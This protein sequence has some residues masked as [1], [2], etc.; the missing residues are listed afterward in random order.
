[1]PTLKHKGC[2]RQIAN[3]GRGAATRA[4]FRGTIE[5]SVEGGGAAVPLV[6]M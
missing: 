2:F 4:C 1:M 5:G 6:R 3:R